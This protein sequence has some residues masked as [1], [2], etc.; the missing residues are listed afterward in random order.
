MAFQ[1]EQEEFWAGDFGTEYIKRNQG[2]ALLASNLNFFSKSLSQVR[3]FNSC[4]EFGANIGMNLK[5]LKL[6]THIL[7]P[8]QLKL[9]KR[10]PSIWVRLYL[11]HRSTIRPYLTLYH[12]VNGTWHSLR[13]C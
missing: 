9:T 7:M 12:R 4:I 2:E 11:Q 8:M 3:D 1:T 5:A 6:C 13:V 10:L